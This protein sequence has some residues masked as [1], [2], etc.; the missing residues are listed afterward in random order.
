MTV[1]FFD[2]FE[3]ITNATQFAE[4]FPDTNL[5][6]SFGSG[7]FAGRSINYFGGAYFAWAPFSTTSANL[8]VGFAYQ[9]DRTGNNGTF[10]T[11]RDAGNGDICDLRLT[12]T[13]ALQ[14]TRNGT[15]LGTSAA[16]VLAI[17][18]WAYIEVE[19][20]RHATAGVFNVYVNGTAVLSLSSQNT[21]A[22]DITSIRID[23]L[24]QV[25]SF[26]DLY[27]TDSSTRLGEC[28]VDLLPPS[29]D[30]AQKDFTPSTGTT[31]Y[32]MVN[33]TQY[34]EDTN[35]VS[36]ATV[37]NKDLY[38]V[39]DLPFTPASVYAVKVTWRARKDDAT[40]RTVR[41]N[42]KS[43]ATTAN[44]ATKA[45][46]ASYQSYSDVYVTDPNTSAAWTVSAVNAIQVGPEIIS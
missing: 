2:G 33:E 1:K 10:L 14:A 41:A 39:T 46:G 7:R 6:P 27:T 18:A 13:A 28:R 29:A 8:S 19:F 31:N 4:R 12:A 37:G 43:G 21:G 36:A 30:T 23:G 20:V 25:Q 15:V 3:L 22:T 34:N 26:D 17:N 24:N 16:G 9:I 35:Y 38:D 32:N 45:M 11:F 40:T 42:L 44:G 5:N